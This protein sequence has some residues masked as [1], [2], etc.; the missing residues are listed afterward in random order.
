MDSKAKTIEGQRLH[1]RPEQVTLNARA[2]F[3]SVTNM[4]KR[5]QKRKEAPRVEK[6]EK[7]APLYNDHF[8]S[9]HLSSPARSV[10]IQTPRYLHSALPFFFQSS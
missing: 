9:S 3:D 10:V 7:I 8:H 1:Y 5:R 2:S 4:Y 6:W